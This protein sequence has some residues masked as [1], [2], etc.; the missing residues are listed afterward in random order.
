MR[1]LPSVSLLHKAAILICLISVMA[2]PSWSPKLVSELVTSKGVVFLPR[3]LCVYMCA[4]ACKYSICVCVCMCVMSCSCLCRTV[5]PTH[6][7]TATHNCGTHREPFTILAQTHT[8]KIV[9]QT[10][11]LITQTCNFGTYRG[12]YPLTIMVHRKG[13]GGGERQREGQTE[14]KET[15]CWYIQTSIIL[16]Q[17]SSHSQFW[18]WV[19][20]H[21]GLSQCPPVRAMDWSGTALMLHV[22]WNRV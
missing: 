18:Q 5:F 22:S 15:H 7:G 3:C 11:K 21:H 1:V 14:T 9:P 8:P 20:L 19:S 6:R 10:D 12:R 17:R 2:L 16:L 13:G 4:H